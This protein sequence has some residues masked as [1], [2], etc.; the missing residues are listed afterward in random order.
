MFIST[1]GAYVHVA[2]EIFE[3]RLKEKKFQFAP[4]KVAS[5]VIVTDAAISTEALRLAFRHNIDVLVLD[6]FGTPMGRFWHAR[7]GSTAAIRRAQIEAA[8]KDIGLQLAREWMGERLR[9]QA[10]LLRKLGRARKGQSATDLFEA[11]K[12]IT[13]LNRKLKGIQGV[14]SQV[15]GSLM[16]IEGSAARIYFGAMSRALPGQWQFEGRSRAPAKDPFNAFL[17]YALGVLYG[18]CEKSIV[19]AGL[20]PYVGFLHTDN[21]NKLA[22]VFDIIEPR[23]VWAEDVVF[24]LFSGRKARPGMWDEIP[25]GY[26]LNQEGKQVLLERFNAYLDHV[27]VYRKRKLSRRNTVLADCHRTAG[28]LLG[29]SR[30]IE[31]VE[32]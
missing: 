15:R 31:A 29:Y 7:F 9:G 12:E 6:E 1:R 3:I 4:Q 19:L 30:E 25:G 20:D 13:A 14:V 8:D 17:N 2:G 21:Y 10:E 18:I 32:V 23:R 22:L 27:V 26:T 5:I 24:H 16:G 11:A 28:L